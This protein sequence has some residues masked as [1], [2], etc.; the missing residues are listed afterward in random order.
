MYQLYRGFP[1]GQRESGMLEL[2]RQRSSLFLHLWIESSSS[3]LCIV[4][5][6]WTSWNRWL[7][8]RKPLSATVAPAHNPSCT[9]EC[10][11]IGRRNKRGRQKNPVTDALYTAGFI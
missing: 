6:K 7:A 8:P 11:N 10:S 2:P 3:S 5:Q 4:N 1:L 9:F